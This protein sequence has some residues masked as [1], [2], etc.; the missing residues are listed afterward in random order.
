MFCLIEKI[1]HNGFVYDGSVIWVHDTSIL[2]YVANSIRSHYRVII[3]IYY[4]FF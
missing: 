4:N 3:F 2:C 1:T